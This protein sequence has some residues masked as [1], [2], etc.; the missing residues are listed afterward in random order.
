MCGAQDPCNEWDSDNP[1]RCVDS[2]HGGHGHSHAVPS[3]AS[4]DT[5]EIVPHHASH[6]HGGHDGEGVNINGV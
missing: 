6:D 2:D 4:A 1:D 3:A 5:A